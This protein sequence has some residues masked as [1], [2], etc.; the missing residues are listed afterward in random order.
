MPVSV[1]LRRRFNFAKANWEQFSRTIDEALL[2]VPPVPKNYDQFVDIVSRTSRTLIPRGCRTSYIPG[3]SNESAELL[4]EYELLYDQD[5]FSEAATLAGEELL[6]QIGGNRQERWIST[7]TNIDMTHNSKKAWNTI[8]KLT[9]DPAPPSSSSRVTANQIAHT[10]LL[11]GKS[12]GRLAKVPKPNIS[13]NTCDHVSKPFS[14]NDIVTTIKRLKCGKASGVDNIAVE[15]LKHLGPVA[16]SWLLLMFNKCLESASI[17]CLW[18]KSKVI[19]IPKPGKPTDS[20]K[21]FRP[22]SLLCH[23]YKLFERL[24]LSRL[25]SLIDPI[26]IP[27]QAGFRPV[28]SCSNQTLKLTQHI[29]DGFELKK[30]TGAVFVDLSA[31]Y[32]TVNLRRLLW[33]VELRLATANLSQ[34]SEN[35]FTTVAFRFIFFRTRVVGGRK[36]MAY[37][38]VAS[39]LRYSSIC[40][41]TTNHPAQTPAASSTQTILH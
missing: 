1:P 26:L 37:P 27:E 35:S 15:Q 12:L 14:L 17:P 38:K 21:N 10:L 9:T 7:V 19:A 32:D 3:L 8:R 34:F 4:K 11:N 18:R 22:I 30:I 39:W 5:P 20:P 6:S 25:T 23:T 13:A 2:T 36:I 16:V 41:P 33:K 29:E 40:T 31:A 24:L 28:K